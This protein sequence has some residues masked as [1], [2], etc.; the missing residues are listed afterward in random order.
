[1]HEKPLPTII[2][3]GYDLSSWFIEENNIEE[4]PDPD[5]LSEPFYGMDPDYDPPSWPV[6]PDP[7]I[8]F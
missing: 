6:E 8:P 2:F 4:E 1:M 3:D 7:E 5:Y